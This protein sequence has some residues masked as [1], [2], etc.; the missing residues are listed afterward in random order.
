[1]LNMDFSRRVVINTSSEQWLPSPAQGVWRRPLARE[2]AERG[3][4]TSIV[5]YEPGASFRGH[6]HP[7]GEEIFVLQGTFSDETGD[8]G[9]GCY[10]RNPPGFIHAPYS[11][12]GCVILVKLHQFMAADLS[13]LAIDTSCT[14]WLESDNGYSHLPLHRF[15]TELVSL[16]RLRKNASLPEACWPGGAEMLVIGGELTNRN[17]S[18]P[19]GTWLRLPPG[20]S[21]NFISTKNSKVWLKQGHLL[22]L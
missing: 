11:R 18:Y 9:P 15:D 1:M 22:Q 16:F 19:A 13:R 5:R 20:S 14:S 21:E 4:A 6:N 12:N 2:D 3:H 10:F 8:F 7:L 17:G